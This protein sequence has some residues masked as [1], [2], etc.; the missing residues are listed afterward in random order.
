MVHPRDS[1]SSSPTVSPLL[2]TDAQLSQN[3]QAD[4]QILNLINRR[5]EATK[6]FLKIYLTL[7][8]LHSS[9]YYAIFSWLKMCAGGL[10]D[11]KMKIPRRKSLE[12][13]ETYL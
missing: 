5:P 9:N 6:K 3:S 8:Y 10:C 1:V 2:L 4:V 7:V 11:M 13:K 12:F